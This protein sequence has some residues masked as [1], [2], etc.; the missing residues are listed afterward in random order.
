MS[1]AGRPG[2]YV[3]YDH[4]KSTEPLYDNGD[5]VQGQCDCCAAFGLITRCWY[6]GIETFAC[7]ECQGSEPDF[8]REGDE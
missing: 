6:A 5:P 8:D 2:Y 4:R 7:D 3:T 1:K